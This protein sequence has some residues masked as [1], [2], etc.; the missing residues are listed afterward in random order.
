[1]KL[2]EDTE[3]D[4]MFWLEQQVGLVEKIGIESYIQSQI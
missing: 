2:L 1:L 4:H 3:E